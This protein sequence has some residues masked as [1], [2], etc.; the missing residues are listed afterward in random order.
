MRLNG[1]SNCIMRIDFEYFKQKLVSPKCF[2]IIFSL[3]PCVNLN[4]KL[5]CTC[6]LK[7]DINIS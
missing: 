1:C 6:V 3:V 4:S 2:V 7:S 5:K